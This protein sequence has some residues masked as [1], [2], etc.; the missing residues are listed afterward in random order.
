MKTYKMMV[1]NALKKANIQY[2]DEQ[3]EIAATAMIE[4]LRS[5]YIETI[6]W[7]EEGSVSQRAIRS[8]QQ[9]NP[10]V[11]IVLYKKGCPIPVTQNI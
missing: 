6:I 11:K 10:E 3:L 7:I 9:R 8:I 1:R 2:N 4:E 5:R